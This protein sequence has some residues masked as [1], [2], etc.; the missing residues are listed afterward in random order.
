M[1]EKLLI[2]FKNCFVGLATVALTLFYPAVSFA[3]TVV[4]CTPPSINEAGVHVPT[5]A[6]AAMYHYDCTLQ[7]WVS[8]HYTFNP[9]TSVTTPLDPQVYT[10]NQATGLWDVSIWTYIASS[11]SYQLRTV[12]VT[13]PPAGATTVGGPVAVATNTS[14]TISSNDPSQ[15]QAANTT[16]VND[17]NNT[18]AQIENNLSSSAVSGNANVLA[19]TTA[20]N[21][22]SGNTQATAT[23][24][25]MVQS[26]VSGFSPNGNVVT[27]TAN[28]N[29]DVNG[30]LLL[31]PALISTV[32]PATNAAV[33]NP[34]TVNAANNTDQTV[35]NNIG[36][37]AQS[38]DATVTKNTTAGN[39]T[40]GS[41]DVIA[42]VVNVLNSAITSGQSF[43]GV[44][45]INGNLN[46]DILLPPNFIDQLLAS[47]VPTVNISTNLNLNNNVN[48]TITNNV[49]TDASTGQAVVGQNTTAGNATSGK[50]TTGI[51][52]FNLTGSNIIGS[53]DLLVFVNVLGTWYGM[54]FNAPGA[55]SASLGGGITTNTVANSNTNNNT[56]QAITN[57]INLAAQS[58]DATV[59]KNT[60]AGNATSGNAAAAVN[61]LNVANSSISLANWFG[62]LFINV[63][64]SWNGSFGI[65]TA[66]GDA[67]LATTPSAT[68]SQTNTQQSPTIPSGSQLFRFVASPST[69]GSTFSPVDNSSADTS[70]GPAVLAASITKKPFVTQ[71]PAAQV[72]NQPRANLWL[73]A[74]GATLGI[75]MLLAERI[76]HLRRS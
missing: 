42:N 71:T 26:S 65:N 63:F 53:N 3:D 31:N 50:A 12:S 55:T 20:G 19:N 2:I 25:N 70:E 51:T 64:G 61:I 37:S 6:D 10:Y 16:N 44:I 36:L 58:G 24:I 29:G 1:T 54:I 75:G 38:G 66:A 33:D 15:V 5:G 4:T 21:A 22:L 35:T 48:Q 52:A 47:N 67:P 40:S 18:T 32:Q 74:L 76:R 41:A 59:T 8:D 72:S 43:L 34:I 17:T 73:P 45:N 23:V 14:P 30:D 62:I 7:L 39:A 27:F 46:G 11:S 9:Y 49:T 60:T 56:N 13:T 57:N 68:T 28:I 69:T